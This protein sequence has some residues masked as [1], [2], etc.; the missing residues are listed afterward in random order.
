[1]LVPW[2][3]GATLAS[4]SPVCAFRHPAHLARVPTIGSGAAAGLTAAGVRS[5]VR[6]ALA[7]PAVARL[8]EQHG[9][10]RIGVSTIAGTAAYPVIGGLA[11]IRLGEPAAYSGRLP[12]PGGWGGQP[13]D[14]DYLGLMDV[15]TSGLRAFEVWV[16]L[17]TRRVSRVDLVDASYQ[18]WRGWA[19]RPRRLSHD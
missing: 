15:T 7:Q 6:I 1:M 19:C 10:A 9:I 13:D 17:A 2:L 18:Q 16:N 4:S 8:V 3:V 14:T 5:V 12:E 11:H